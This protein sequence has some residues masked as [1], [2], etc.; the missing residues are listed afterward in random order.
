VLVASRDAA[1]QLVHR[2]CESGYELFQPS[3]DLVALE[4]MLRRR[5]RA[6]G[7]WVEIDLHRQAW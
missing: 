5:G 7:V 3:G 6:D 4:M 2:L 1:D